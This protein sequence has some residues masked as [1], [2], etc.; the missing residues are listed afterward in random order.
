MRK[1]MAIL[2]LGLLSG[3]ST[4]GGMFQPSPVSIGG[5]ADQL[6]RTP[7]ACAEIEQQPGMP[8]FLK[9]GAS[10]AKAA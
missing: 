10:P 2:A 8:D 7:C 6:K 3:C 9:E 4:V 5:G 1:T